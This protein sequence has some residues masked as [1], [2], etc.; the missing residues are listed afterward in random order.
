[1]NRTGPLRDVYCAAKTRGG[2]TLLELCI[3]LLIV[4]ILL[5]AMIPAIHSAFVESGVRADARQ[6]SLLVK[7]AMLQSADQDRNYVLDLSTGSLDLH[8]AGITAKDDDAASSSADTEKAEADE[9]S[10]S[11]DADIACRIDRAN[12]LLVPDPKKEGAWI[13]IQATS[14]LFQPGDLCPATR[15]RLARGSSYLEMSFNA[16]T[17]NVENETAYFP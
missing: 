4:G 10:V 1:M 5:G 15:V 14:W 2:F 17:G 6:L 16:L 9:S 8:P 11:D 3:V 7:T 13:N 12:R